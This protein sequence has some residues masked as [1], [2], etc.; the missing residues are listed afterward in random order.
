[1]NPV[2]SMPIITQKAK[3][4]KKKK[5]SWVLDFLPYSC[6]HGA[7]SDIIT[8]LT[9]NQLSLISKKNLNIVYHL[10]VFFLLFW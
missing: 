10:L 2:M 9:L 4:K 5:T 7:M 6:D 8:D 1:M 3:R